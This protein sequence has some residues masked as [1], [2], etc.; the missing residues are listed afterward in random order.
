L[1]LVLWLL[2]CATALCLPCCLSCRV[3]CRHGRSGGGGIAGP[4]EEERQ[5]DAAS[6]VLPW[7]RVG[8]HRDSSAARRRH[9]LRGL[10][11]STA[12]SHSTACSGRGR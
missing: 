6:D 5:R 10:C 9:R 7:R 11:R 2:V 8:A 4:C 1:L 12:G 3:M